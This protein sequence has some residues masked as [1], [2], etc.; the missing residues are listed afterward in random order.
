VHIL[1]KN[2]AIGAMVGMIASD[3]YSNGYY[4]KFLKTDSRGGEIEVVGCI[5]AASKI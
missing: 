4:S 1:I 3:I 5:N 2:V